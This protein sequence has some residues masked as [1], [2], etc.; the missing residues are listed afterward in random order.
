MGRRQWLCAAGA[1][2][3]GGQAHALGDSPADQLLVGMSMNNLLSLDP[4]A[5]TGLDAMTVACNL[6]DSLL[7]TDPHGLRLRWPRRGK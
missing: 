2:L 4:G 6:Y 7:E 5:A 3:C 1:A